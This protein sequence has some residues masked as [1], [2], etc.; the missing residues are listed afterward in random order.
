MDEQKYN[1]TKQPIMVFKEKKSPSMKR[2]PSFAES[3]F[4]SGSEDI[5]RSKSGG[6]YK[7]KSMPNDNKISNNIFKTPSKISNQSK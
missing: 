1:E 5:G 6:V 4:A 7:Q 2:S 3:G